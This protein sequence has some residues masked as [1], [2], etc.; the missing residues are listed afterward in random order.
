MTLSWLS[1]RTVIVMRALIALLAVAVSTRG[2]AGQQTSP[3]I[4]AGYSPIGVAVDAAGI[5]YLADVADQQIVK[6]S[7]DGTL[8]GRIAVPSPGAVTVDSCGNLYVAQPSFVTVLNSTGGQLAKFPLPGYNSYPVAVAL[9]QY[10][11]MYIVD[12]NNNQVDKMTLDG[13]LLATLTTSNPEMDTPS[14]VALDVSGNVYVADSHNSRVVKFDATGVQTAVYSTSSPIGVA[15]DSFGNLYVS[16]YTAQRI[17]E[18]DA[19]TGAELASFTTPTP[20]SLGFTVIAVDSLCYVYAA[21]INNNRTVIFPPSS[22]WTLSSS[23]GSAVP[24]SCAASPSSLPHSP[25]FTSSSMPSTA[26]TAIT[27]SVRVGNAGT[28]TLQSS[29]VSRG[30]LSGTLALACLYA[31]LCWL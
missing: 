8:I 31:V 25:S 2:A 6:L 21:D 29:A 17:L 7:N 9:D 11:Y 23:T 30:V 19:K 26:S 15:L 14:T 5:I 1:C 22:A 18:L 24:S 27:S 3:R 12:Q 10:G 4:I 16:E 13:T 20:P 28:A